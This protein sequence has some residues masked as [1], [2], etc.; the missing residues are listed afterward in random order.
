MNNLIKYIFCI[1]FVLYSANSFADVQSAMDDVFGGLVNVT[2]GAVVQGQNRNAFVAGSIY[3]RNRII[4]PQL[5]ALQAPNFDAGCRGIDLYG[6]SFSFINKDNFQQLLRSIASNAAGYAFKLALEGM[7]PTCAQ[8]MASLQKTVNN[9]NRHMRD[10]CQIATSLVDEVGIQSL[11]GKQDESVNAISTSLGGFDD[12]LDA[13][14]EPKTNSEKASDVGSVSEFERNVVWQ[15]IEDAGG[16][17]WLINNDT[18]VVSLLM[19]L[20]GTIIVSCKAPAAG[21]TCTDA[22]FTYE[23]KDS[24]IKL[25]HLLEGSAREIGGQVAL[26]ECDSSRPNCLVLNE[27]MTTFQGFKERVNELLNGDGTSVGIITKQVQGTPA[28]T[29]EEL[30]LIETAPVPIKVMLRSLSTH[31]GVA[32]TFGVH[33]SD[34][35]AL[36]IAIEMA[37]DIIRAARTSLVGMDTDGNQFFLK[38]LNELNAEIEAERQALTDN[39]QNR[40]DLYVFFDILNRYRTDNLTEQFSSLVSGANGQS[41]KADN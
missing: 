31:S 23:S 37:S 3:Q 20:T 24:T 32:Q 14:F 9:I 6:G 13:K 35:I 29:S 15:A 18:D 21:D 7:C 30:S 8:T 17:N 27:T 11:F 38:R 39:F 25:E 5:I 12:W 19:S 2:P 10:S 33:A 34:T 41:K 36:E 16:S 1:T 22:N 4:T 26:L 28:L 40:N